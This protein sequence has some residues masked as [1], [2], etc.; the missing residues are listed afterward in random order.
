MTKIKRFSWALDLTKNG[1]LS[2]W[3]CQLSSLVSNS[4]TLWILEWCDFG[5]WRGLLSAVWS[6]MGNSGKLQWFWSWCLVELL[7]NGNVWFISDL[8]AFQTYPGSRYLKSALPLWASPKYLLTPFHSFYP[9]TFRHFATSLPVGR[10]GPLNVK[11]TRSPEMNISI[12]SSGFD[13]S[14]GIPRTWPVP[15]RKLK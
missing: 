14:D 2:F 12:Y 15:T 1:F 7:H 6:Y 8:C 3:I 11:K 9:G 4:L 13:G 10:F 5:W